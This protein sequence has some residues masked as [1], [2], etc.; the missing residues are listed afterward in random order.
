MCLLISQGVSKFADS[1][2]DENG[3]FLRPGNTEINMVKIRCSKGRGVSIRVA[4]LKANPELRMTLD[5][6]SMARKYYCVR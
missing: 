2:T 3:E 5:F 4:S 1:L 6:F